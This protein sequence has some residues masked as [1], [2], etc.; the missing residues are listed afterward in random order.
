M[1]HTWTIVQKGKILGTVSARDVQEA[2]KK[3]EYEY[4]QWNG[5]FLLS[6][7]AIREGYGNNLAFTLEED[8]K[9]KKRRR[10]PKKHMK[11]REHQYQ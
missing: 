7:D 1:N 2:I 9:G 11:R 5:K 6:E 4:P 3:G 8:S 10:K